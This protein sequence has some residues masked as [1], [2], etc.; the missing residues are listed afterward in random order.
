MARGGCIGNVSISRHPISHAENIGNDWTS[1]HLTPR[2]ESIG[3][4]RISRISPTSR[5]PCS[6]MCSTRCVPGLLPHV[7][8]RH[9]D[10]ATI[11][12][13]DPI[14]ITIASV[15]RMTPT[16][17]A[18]GDPLAGLRRAIVEQIK[19]DYWTLAHVPANELFPDAEFY[20]DRIA[21]NQEWLREL[22][23]E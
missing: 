23:E 12:T 18:T 6:R 17:N 15:T 3:S 10:G 20:I 22:S 13:T 8:G 21:A 16:I 9:R 4:G 2:A 19:R 14:L 5:R 11:V 7:N 1:Q